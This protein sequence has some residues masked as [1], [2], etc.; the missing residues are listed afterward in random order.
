VDDDVSLWGT[1][2]SSWGYGNNRVSEA[3]A[4][5]FKHSLALLRPARLRISV[6]RKGGIYEDADRRL[7]KAHFGHKGAD[8][9]LQVT[10][11]VIE[12]RMRAGADRT[13]DFSGSAICVSLS[14]IY[15]GDAYKLVAGVIEPF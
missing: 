6:G 11:P 3:V 13:E 8:Y 5:G 2:S 1:G 9:T 7:V 15:R 14:G 10:D 4:N 12:A